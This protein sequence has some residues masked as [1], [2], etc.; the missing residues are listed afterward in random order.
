MSVGDQALVAAARSRLAEIETDYTR[1]HCAVEATQANLFNLVREHYQRRDR[2]R[3]IVDHRRRYLKVLMASGGTHIDR[4]PERNRV[5][6]SWNGTGHL[7]RS[8]R[9][10]T[11]SSLAGDG[12]ARVGID[13]PRM[14][15]AHRD[16]GIARCRYET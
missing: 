13:A 5:R 10:R 8:S 2:L 7:Y 16:G 12:S 9:A 3:L 15:S 1:D 6:T 4:E 14:R 11:C